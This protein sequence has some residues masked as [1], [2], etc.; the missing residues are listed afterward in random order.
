MG[1]LRHERMR[2]GVD[3]HTVIEASPLYDV[4]SGAV[5]SVTFVNTKIQKIDARHAKMGIIIL[6]RYYDVIF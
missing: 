2:Q 3:L 6:S 5:S 4:F 1:Q